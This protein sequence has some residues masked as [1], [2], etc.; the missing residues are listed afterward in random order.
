MK[1]ADR[2][3]MARLFA[4]EQSA[5]WHTAIWSGFQS[6]YSDIDQW[7]I[8]ITSQVDTLSLLRAPLASLS[9][10]PPDIRSQ[11][12][13]TKIDDWFRL[14]I[15]R[16]LPAQSL[17]TKAPTRRFGYPPTI[18]TPYLHALLAHVAELV[19]RGIP[20]KAISCSNQERQ[21]ATDILAYH[22]T[23]THSGN[24]EL[25]DLLRTKLRVHF[26]PHSPSLTRWRFLCAR[27][28]AKFVYQSNANKHV[29]CSK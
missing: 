15:L 11:A 24:R 26:N 8:T 25:G 12:L 2:S 23:V 22:R 19:E 29:C 16:P 7:E 9:T 27:C 14:L 17:Y 3:A 6:I 10:A 4:D 20:F 18:I 1:L 5:E 21:N 13:Q 28:D